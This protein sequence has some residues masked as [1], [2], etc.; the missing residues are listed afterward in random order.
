VRVL[1]CLLSLSWFIAVLPLPAFAQTLS[2]SATETSS[3][4]TPVIKVNSNLVVLDVVATD[5]S[6]RVV[7]DLKKEDFTVFENGVKQTLG[8]FESPAGRAPIAATPVPDRNG[9]PTWGEAPITIVVLDQLNTPID[10]I[11]FAREQLF[12]YLQAQ[13][14]ELAE[15]TSLVV[16]NDRGIQEA[17][18]TTRDRE[19]LLSIARHQH[20]GLPF[21]LKRGATDEM[22]SESFALLR[23][24]ALS[25]RGDHGRKNVIW[26]GRGFPGLDPTVLDPH[27]QETFLNAVRDTVNM[28]LDARV[29]ISKIDPRTNLVTS[30]DPQDLTG[31]VAP[32][33]PDDPFAT[34][35]SF[36]AFIAQTGGRNFMYMNDLSREIQEG[37][38]QGSNYYTMSYVPT[39]P[40]EDGKYHKLTILVNRPGVSL[41]AKEGF[42]AGKAPGQPGVEPSDRELGFDMLQA[43]LSGMQ[44]NGV[45]I[46][47]GDRNWDEK[48]G[49]LV[50]KVRVD[51]STLSFE[52][53]PGGDEK[54]TFFVSMAALDEKG[55]VLTFK[56][57]SPTVSIPA[58]QTSQIPTGHTTVSAVLTLPQRTRAVRVIVRDSS[59]R[60]GTADFDAAYIAG[61][62]WHLPPAVGVKHGRG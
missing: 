52:P 10:E 46:Q 6:A 34:T 44:Y 51:T 32:G 18:P 13:P 37:V 60:I 48:S 33:V 47:L 17:S 30:L 41:R 57:V 45:G 29:T 7:T 26:I 15:P 38:S 28:L 14:E 20:V 31:M 55:K 4:P 12:K 16:L 27:D 25:T 3:R 19:A 61:L 1:K 21:R 43:A 2:Q 53:A 36:N 40:A 22:L 11:A 58:I 56:S 59:G 39:D 50:V 5:K 23:Q 49:K 54:T 35:F 8:S 42:Y 62:I 24:I 9:N